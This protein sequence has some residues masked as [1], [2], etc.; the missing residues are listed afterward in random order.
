MATDGFIKFKRR[1]S[2]R[3]YVD[4]GRISA[5]VLPS[6][7]Q[8]SRGD[9]VLMQGE[10]YC[11]YRNRNSVLSEHYHRVHGEQVA[12]VRRNYTLLDHDALDV[13]YD[14]LMNSRRPRWWIWHRGTR[15]VVLGNGQG[16]ETAVRRLTART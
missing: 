4:K 11:R 3:A 8:N 16:A 1:P 9:I 6:P 14:D 12:M 13:W 10:I 7:Q 2:Y 15:G 5:D